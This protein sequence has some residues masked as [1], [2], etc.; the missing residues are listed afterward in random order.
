MGFVCFPDAARIGAAAEAGMTKYSPLS[1]RT[2]IKAT[3]HLA[4]NSVAR[5]CTIHS[6]KKKQQRLVGERGGESV[7]AAPS[8]THL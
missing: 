2:G 1:Q 8:L 5:P 7:A 3:R 4:P 6:Y